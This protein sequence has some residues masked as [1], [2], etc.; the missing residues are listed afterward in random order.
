MRKTPVNS[1]KNIR[2][3]LFPLLIFISL[4]IR[5]YRLDYP[6]MNAEAHRDYVVGRHIIRYLEIPLT[7]PCCLWNGKFGTIRN[8]PSYYYLVPFLTLLILYL[9]WLFHMAKSVSFVTS[10]ALERLLVFSS[11]ELIA[12]TFKTFHLFFES[13]RLNNFWRLIVVF[14]ISLYPILQKNLVQKNRC[15]DGLSE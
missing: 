10:F 15:S 4:F 9:P 2:N 8:S 1:Y 7:G 11:F 13:L 6:L 14:I 3:W 5:L 12:H